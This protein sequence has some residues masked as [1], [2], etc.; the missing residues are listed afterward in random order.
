[1]IRIGLGTLLVIAGWLLLHYDPTDF[2]LQFLAAVTLLIVGVVV[3]VDA[4]L[5]RLR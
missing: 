4:A 2:S 3:L 5:T 1:M